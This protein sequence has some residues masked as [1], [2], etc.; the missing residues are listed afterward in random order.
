MTYN[1]KALKVATHRLNDAR[2]FLYRL[3]QYIHGN[4]TLR[5]DS[6]LILDRLERCKRQVDEACRDNFDTETI[7]RSVQELLMAVNQEMGR[8]VE[9]GHEYEEPVGD[10]DNYAAQEIL[11]WLTDLFEG[12]GFTTLQANRFESQL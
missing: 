4:M 3:Q 9:W 12:L 11:L 6:K 7:V 2:R 5:M 10:R 8:E 1:N